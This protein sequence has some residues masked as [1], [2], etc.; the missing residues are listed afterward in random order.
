MNEDITQDVNLIMQ[1]VYTQNSEESQEPEEEEEVIQVH[2]Y[3]NAIV[4]IKE[5]GKSTSTNIP[6]VDS[7][8]KDAQESQALQIVPYLTVSIFLLLILVSLMFQ[9]YVIVNP[10]TVNLTLAARSQQLTLQGTLQL[11]RLVNPITLSQSA[12]VPTTGKGHQDARSATGTLTFYNGQLQSVFIPAGL[13]LTGTSGEQI[14]TDTDATIPAANPPTWGITTVSAH[15]VTTG[16]SGNISAYDINQG[17][18]VTAIKVVN[19]SSFSG[20]QDE[21]NFQTVAKGDIDLTASQLKDTLNQVTLGA[22]Q[23]ELKAGEVFAIP[24]CNPIVTPDHHIGEEAATVKVTVS[25]MCSA[26][27]YNQDT[28]QSKVTQL[29]TAQAA[30]KLETGYSLL[31]NPQITVTSATISKQVTLSFRS[32]STWVYALSSAEQKHIK[33]IIAGKNT[34][35]AL[36]LLS[37]LP[38]IEHVSMHFAGFGDDTR[39]PKDISRIHM[40]VIYTPGVA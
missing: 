7:T 35:K 9:F 31:G 23:G 10:F 13:M 6:L 24:A 29:L 36:Q 33:T 17:C 28:L 19:T 40:L 27:A 1:Q 30:K 20:G 5:P 15:A 32:V 22:L 26:V 18:C 8:P 11:G 12:T 39:I 3:P 16:S 38:G 14:V 34:D 21:R 2:H 4:I 25:E 37:A